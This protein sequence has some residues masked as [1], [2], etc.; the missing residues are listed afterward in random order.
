MENLC[1][2][3]PH[4]AKRI[5]DQVDNQSLNHCKEISGEILEYLASERFFWIRLVKRYHNHQNPY[6]NRRWKLV[7]DKTPVERVRQIAIAVSRFFRVRH[8][9]SG[10]FGSY[11]KKWSL[12]AISAHHGDLGLLHFIVNKIKL[13]SFKQTEGNNALFLAASKGHLGI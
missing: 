8:L 12:L 4:L 13:K 2:R 3:F 6:Y 1:K 7:I 10:D 9:Y 11:H 5:F